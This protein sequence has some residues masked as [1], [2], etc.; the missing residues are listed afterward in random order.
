MGVVFCGV[1]FHGSLF[2]QNFFTDV[3]FTDRH[4]LGSCKF[5]IPRIAC[6]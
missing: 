1:A 4:I 6:W 2:K 5:R 3:K